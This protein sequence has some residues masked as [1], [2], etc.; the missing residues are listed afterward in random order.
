MSDDK[1]AALNQ[2][3]LA[4]NLYGPNP[5][6]RYPNGIPDTTYSGS[7]T[8]SQGNPIGVPPGMTLNSP[9][10]AAPAAPQVGGG[11][12]AGARPY[13]NWAA[14][15]PTIS[16]DPQIQANYAYN[17]GLGGSID[18][19]THMVAMQGG[20]ATGGA[21]ALA[22][23]GAAP[24]GGNGAPQ[25]NSYQTALQMLSHPNNVPTLGATVP[26]S[27]PITSQPSVLDQF[28]AGQQGGTGAGGYSNQGFFDTLKKLRSNALTSKDDSQG[29]TLNPA[30][31]VNSGVQ[32][33]TL[34]GQQ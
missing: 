22:G 18:P 13:G 25:G 34:G 26:Q 20:G 23:G 1:Q 14:L 9:P 29:T 17:L 12:A 21:G 28:L 15:A 6:T 16:Q 4:G 31:M 32:G 3:I 10:A 7:P 5:Y 30:A 11:A 19:S 2:A 27:Q 33:L 24:A 8:D